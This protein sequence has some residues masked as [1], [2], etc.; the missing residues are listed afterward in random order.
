MITP[1]E[2]QYT[3][4]DPRPVLHDYLLSKY[5]QTTITSYVDKAET[6]YIEYRCVPETKRR[7]F[8]VP[9]VISKKL[10][11]QLKPKP[12][13]QSSDGHSDFVIIPFMNI[14]KVPCRMAPQRN[15]HMIYALYN[16]HTKEVERLD[17][18]KFHI[19]KFGAKMFF[20]KFKDMF[21]PKRF[22]KEAYLS[23]EIDVDTAVMAR[24]LDAP[25]P[26]NSIRAIYPMYL[27][28]YLTMRLKYPKQTSEKIHAKLAKMSTNS[29]IKVW[30]DYAAYSQ[31]YT[32]DKCSKV[33]KVTK[34]N[35]VLVKSSGKL[36]KVPIV[37]VK[38]HVKSDQVLNLE[39]GRCISRKTLQQKHLEVNRTIPDCT[40]EQI[41]SP[42]SHR[43]VKRQSVDKYDINIMM[44]DVLQTKI[45]P[46]TKFIHLGTPKTT[47]P[48]IEHILSKYDGLGFLVK[49]SAKKFKLAW[50]YDETKE[51]H[52]F[53][54]P[55]SLFWKAWEK[56][57][58]SEAR[59]LII[60][61]TLREKDGGV[62]ANVLIFDKE[63]NELER[64]DS[65]GAVVH[66]NYNTDAL[67]IE[68]LK[69]FNSQKG[70]LVPADY[71][72]IRPKDF[73]AAE[74]FQSK[75]TDEISVEDT[76][77]N[78]AVWRAWYIDIRLANPDVLRQHLVKIAM[79]KL[80]DF[81]SLST[82]IKS[83]QVHLSQ[84]LPK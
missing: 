23:G 66:E 35:K 26:L 18:K 20:K 10:K 74:L 4:G 48:V 41:F 9:D 19:H 28:N 34:I 67:D 55:H 57:I 36:K 59:F 50:R 27:V 30:Q 75:E 16:R 3:F 29:L 80:E 73:C 84:F 15:K 37:Q 60:L 79:Q 52:Y 33:T 22:P 44:K 45:T 70:K 13:Q 76:R 11:K 82:F 40:S 81:G 77:G 71:K 2:F 83:Y 68:I 12:E 32:P 25:P 65:I 58:K 49:P 1:L 7:E 43:C 5:P 47:V 54:V 24:F 69:L 39:T 51:R 8:Y 72:Y 53:Q 56:G 63:N 17:I 14:S 31:S 21:M 61:M 38:Q 46:K 6:K 62:H 64:F 42:I 78:C